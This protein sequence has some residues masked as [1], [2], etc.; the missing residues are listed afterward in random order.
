MWQNTTSK[1]LFQKLLKFRKLTGATRKSFLCLASCWRSS[2]GTCSTEHGMYNTLLCC[3]SRDGL[4]V[5]S[6]HV[7]MVS[8]NFSKD[9]SVSHIQSNSVVKLHA[10]VTGR[11]KRMFERF[12]NGLELDSAPQYENSKPLRKVGT[13]YHTVWKPLRMPSSAKHVLLLYLKFTMQAFFPNLVIYSSNR[14]ILMNTFHTHTV[15][16]L[17]TW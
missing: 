17:C 15:R 7:V 1:I 9:K 12:R 2:E 14:I 3:S 11:M 8:A 6:H 10:Q 16:R 13:L 4:C 5:F